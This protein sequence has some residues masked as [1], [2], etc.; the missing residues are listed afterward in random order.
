MS[1]LITQ[2]NSAEMNARASLRR[3]AASIDARLRHRWF[4]G[5]VAVLAALVLVSAL[6]GGWQFDD[7]FQRSTILGYGDAS[8]IQIFVPYDGNPLHNEKQIEFGT[9]PWWASRHLHLAFLRYTSTLS[10][11]LDY[12]LWPN[13]PELMHLHS[14]LWL[15]AAVLAAALLY[16]ALLG[17][18]WVAGLAALLYALD[19]AHAEPASYL[20]DR[21]ALIAC[22]FGFF[23]ILTF[24]RWREHG[25]RWDRWLSLLLLVLALSAGEMSLATVAYLLAYALILDR[26]TIRA[27][28][29]ALLPHIGVLGAWALV[30]R[31]ANFGSNG[32][33]FYLDPLRDPFGFAAGFWQHAAFLLMGQWTPVPAEMSLVFPP[34]TAAALHLS[35]FSVVVVAVLAG[36]FIPLAVRDRVARFWGLGVL[37]S[38]V[39]IAAVGPENRL[40]GFVGLGSMGLLAQLVQAAFAGTSARLAHRAW[41]RFSQAAV[42]VLLPLHLFAAPMVGIAQVAYR[43]KASSRMVR[44]ISSVPNVPQIAAQTLVLVNPPDHIYLVTAIPVVKQLEKL[45]VPRRMRALSTGSA[46]EITRVGTRSIRVR[47]PQGFFPTAFSRY[48]RSQNDRFSPG[49]RLKLPGL[50]VVVESLDAQGDPEQVLYEFSVPLE[51]P[52]LRWMRWQDGVYVPWSPPAVGHTEKL[53]AVRG[54][55]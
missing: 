51:D 3:A 46:L 30:Y 9:L 52:S 40:L 41:K 4:S 7:H 45:P 55:F 14:L 26:G 38:L 37:L 28:I 32:S 19:G 36:L 47:F 18:T 11:L 50:S 5:V 49:Q 15:C 1:E 42:V 24:V 54:I 31:L 44:A 12:W 22:C 13:H 8:P 17:A 2:R 33:G 10:T 53:P 6:T 21:N 23:S 29:R 25:L 35:V 43:A 20:A 16:R 34:G 39:P 48:V 27:K